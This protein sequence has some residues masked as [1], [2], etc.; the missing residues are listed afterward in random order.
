MAD[1]LGLL[2]L[3]GIALV[4]LVG[5]LTALLVREASRPPRHSAAYAIARSLPCDPGELELDFE[6]WTLDR[7]GDV[8]LPVW[9]VATG[10]NPGV[11]GF[12]GGAAVFVH[13]WGQSRIDMLARIEPWCSLCD[14]L[15]LYDLRGH[16]DAE[17]GLSPLG[18]REE[19]DLIELLRRL[20]D[21]RVI[22]VG[23]SMGAVVAIHAAAQESEVKDHIAGIAAYG[24]YAD[25]H[26]SVQGR[27]RVAGYPA[28]PITDLAMMWLK[29]C[30]IRHR[31]VLD[32]VPNV[33]CPM[34]IIHGTEDIVSPLSHARSIAEAAVD[35]TLLEIEGGGHLD[36]HLVD[37]QTHD[38]AVGAF[39]ARIGAGVAQTCAV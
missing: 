37:P 12:V 5:V 13:G 21:E 29:L 14:R 32:D 26:T 20:G 25:F 39:L 15:V 17:G 2:I 35:A 31:R 6:E 9:E 23:H 10:A 18:C 30:G 28:R 3:L 34:L 36:A 16:G 4:V 8:K 27:L 38:E 11:G 7:S 19:E 1:L 33:A 22:L 24:P